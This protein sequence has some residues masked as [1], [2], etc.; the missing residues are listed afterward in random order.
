MKKTISFGKIDYYGNGRKSCEVTLDLGLKTR[1]CRDWV[2]NEESEM[3][4]FSVSGRVWNNRHTD[5]ICGGQCLDKLREYVK[6]PLFEEIY[7]LWEKYHLN[8]LKPGSKAQ[9]EIVEKWRKENNI[10]GWAYNEECTLLESKGLLY[11]NTGS[12]GGSWWCEP[13]PEETVNRIKQIIN[14]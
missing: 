8:N 1:V 13:I 12:Y 7:N 4:I 9:C 3:D 11:D 2:N 5:I 14:S 6:N 10:T